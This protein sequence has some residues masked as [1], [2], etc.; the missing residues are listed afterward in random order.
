MDQIQEIDD[1]L[2]QR[3]AFDQE[4]V[5]RDLFGVIPFGDHE[6][7]F[8]LLDAFAHQRAVDVNDGVVDVDWLLG[9][10]FWPVGIRL[11]R[12]IS[13]FIFYFLLFLHV[14]LIP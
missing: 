7:A 6:T 2:V 8:H 11:G 3:R 4:F 9:K 5:E 10:Y 12:R 13:G 1:V 14:F